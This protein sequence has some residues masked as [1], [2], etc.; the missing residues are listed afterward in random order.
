M[1]SGLS[2]L[3]TSRE[4]QRQM[5]ELLRIFSDTESRDE[6]GIGQVRDAFSDLLFP[7]TS[8]LHTRAKYLLIVPW[9]YR[10]AEERGLRGSALAARV[11]KCERRVIKTLKDAGE[12]DGLIGRVAGVAVKTLPS[13]IYWGA[14]GQYRIRL[15]EET[16]G[17]PELPGVEAEELAE[18]AAGDWAPSLPPVPTG[19]PQQ[20]DVGLELTADEAAWLRERMLLGAPDSLLAHFLDDDN[21]PYDDSWA[22]WVDPAAATAPLELAQLLGHAELFSLTIHGAALLYNLLIA[23]HYERA[24]HSTIEEPIRYYRE[25]ITDWWDVVAAEGRMASWDRSAMWEVVISRNPRIAG[26][27]RMRAFVD[28]WLNAVVD[29]TARDAADDDGLRRLVEDRERS[30]KRTQSR[31]G[32]NRLL[33]TWS[34]G[35]GTRRLTYRWAQVRRLLLDVHNGLE[36]SDAAP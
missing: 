6:I 36:S 24:G 26:N 32:E 33:R 25:A 5:A 4:E 15:G 21:R 29:G 11:E 13:T 14:L 30:V 1:G 10:E 23:E 27:V 12:V 19:F 20:L 35:S 22:P 9:C 16:S 28:L 3:D 31:L 7:G 17:G 2:W 8:T 34:G 18:R